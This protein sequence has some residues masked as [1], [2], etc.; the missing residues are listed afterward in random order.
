[1]NLSDHEPL[2]L[3]LTMPVSVHLGSALSVCRA[4]SIVNAVNGQQC[5]ALTQPVSPRNI[6]SQ[7]GIRPCPAADY[8]LR[9]DRG[10]IAGY[11]EC[12]RVLLQPILDELTCVIHALNNSYDSV[13]T[14]LHL[15]ISALYDSIVCALNQAAH[16]YILMQ[17]HDA[18]KH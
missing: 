16:R 12:T 15:K 3:L 7:H 1:M 8:S 10:N 13:R 4:G 9:F 11:Y 5:S 18:L 14:T 17:K 2:N 6:K